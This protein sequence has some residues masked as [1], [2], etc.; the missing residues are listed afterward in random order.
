MTYSSS[1]ERWSRGHEPLAVVGQPARG[2]R[3]GGQGGDAVAAVDVHRR[4][5][6]GQS[7]HGVEARGAPGV[8]EPAPVVG[9]V[10]VREQQRAQVVQ[11]PAVAVGDLAEDALVRHLQQRELVAAVAA[12]LREPQ[13][14]ACRLRGVDQAPELGQLG[15]DR[16]LDHRVGPGLHGG[17]ALGV[18]ELPRGGDVD[19]VELGPVHHLRERPLAPAEL[20]GARVAGGL[21][22]VGCGGGALGPDVADGHDHGAGDVDPGRQH[23]HP[24]VAEADDP[25]PDDVHRLERD[26][27]HGLRAGPGRRRGGGP[28][29][30]TDQG[31]GHQCSSQQAAAG[32]AATSGLDGL[33]LVAH[34]GHSRRIGRRRCPDQPAS[35][36]RAMS[37]CDRNLLTTRMIDHPASVRSGEATSPGPCLPWTPHPPDPSQHLHQT[38]RRTR[39]RRTRGP[40]PTAGPPRSVRR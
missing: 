12:V 14:L 13:V 20:G 17:L 36:S 6:R 22:Q 9:V 11:V 40:R 29:G 35:P 30:G 3:G 28:G 34:H 18:V 38:P 1:Q 10:A 37:I 23:P 39:W 32:Q 2:R 33:G 31:S 19:E 5:D 7:V 15:R 4:R 8:P 21:D 25:D 27:E 24:P 26:V 16:Q